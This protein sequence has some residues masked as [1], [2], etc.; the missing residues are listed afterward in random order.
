MYV[1]TGVH[2]SLGESNEADGSLDRGSIYPRMIGPGVQPYSD[3]GT[4][5]AIVTKVGV[6]YLEHLHL[7]DVF[8]LELQDYEACSY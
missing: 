6:L 8:L 1:H 4:A 2:F 5:R 7:S 3:T